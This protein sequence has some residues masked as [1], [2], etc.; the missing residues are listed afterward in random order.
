MQDNKKITQTNSKLTASNTT[1]RTLL[2]QERSQKLD[3]LIHL[4]S[5]LRQPLVVCG[6]EGIGKTTFL[7]TLQESRGDQWW[8]CPQQGSAN[9]SFE[10]IINNLNRF[11]DIKDTDNRF[12]LTVL[13]HFC[14]QQKVILMIDDAGELVPGLLGELIAL[15]ESMPKLQLVFSM[16]YDQF[17]IKHASDKTVDDCHFI[18]LPPLNLKQCREFLQNLSAQPGAALSFQAVDDNLVT[19]LYRETHGIPGKILQELPKLDRYQNRKR[20]RIGLWLS[21]T[22][23]VVITGWCITLLLPSFPISTNTIET[24]IAN[25]PEDDKKVTK[26]LLAIPTFS[27][28]KP[29]TPATT[30]QNQDIKENV[31]TPSQIEPVKNDAFNKAALPTISTSEPSSTQSLNQDKDIISQEIKL[32]P[33][34]LP[35]IPALPSTS[36]NAS[37][38]QIVKSAP[39]ISSQAEK[40]T[41]TT[42]PVVETTTLAKTPESTVHTAEKKPDKPVSETDTDDWIQAQPANNYTLQIMVLS[43]KLAASRFIKKY[44]EYS[45]NLK[46]YPITKGIGEPE[47]YVLIYGSFK[48]ANEAKQYK[49]TM[50]NEFKQA[51]EK[52]FRAIQIESRHRN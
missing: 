30:I 26:S 44:D 48:T 5:N 43:N 18:E 11:L 39:V 46:Y 21:I 17:H 35:V 4:L 40:P 34:N 9:L 23:I 16:T 8:I 22:L 49:A 14:E 37:T 45:D 25:Q 13:R 24:S 27:D 19:A 36:T 42:P 7:N 15:S 38:A 12:D 32:Q 28:V 20:S 33:S 6:P 10:T 41:L 47:K 1:M 3:L 31:L 2:S 51:L 52:R 29:D 50:P